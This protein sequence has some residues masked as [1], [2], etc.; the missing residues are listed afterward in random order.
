MTNISDIAYGRTILTPRMKRQRY[1]NSLKSK[2]KALG[3]T[4]H[5]NV[6]YMGKKAYAQR[7]YLKPRQLKKAKVKSSRKLSHYKKKGK[8]FIPVYK[9]VKHIKHRAKPTRSNYDPFNPFGLSI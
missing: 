7:H 9:K 5:K 2:S 1:I 4:I 6:V 3:K 8:K